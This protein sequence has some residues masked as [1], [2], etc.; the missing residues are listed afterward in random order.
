M[1]GAALPPQNRSRINKP[2]AEPLHTQPL[3]VRIPPV[4]RRPA[5]L[6][7]CHDSSLFF[8]SLSFRVERPAFSCAQLLCAGPRRE[9]SAFL[10]DNLHLN[11]AN[12]H[13][14]TILPVPAR[15]LVLVAPL[16]LEHRQH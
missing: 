1:L 7:M 15:N 6:L 8:F 12:L 14:R 16:E 3:S 11:I 5:A 10:F 9:E 13:R 2:P 4:C